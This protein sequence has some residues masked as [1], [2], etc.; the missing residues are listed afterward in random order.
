[1]DKP[2]QKSLGSTFLNAI[3]P[4]ET[5]LAEDF[6]EWLQLGLKTKKI[7]FNTYESDIHV[8]E[9]GLFLEIPDI[10]K[11][12]CAQSTK[13]PRWDQVFAQLK[14]IGLISKDETRKELS[15][16][17][18]ANDDTHKQLA[19]ILQSDLY[20][21]KSQLNQV[22]QA[23]QTTKPNKKSWMPFIK[24][25]VRS[26]VKILKPYFLFLLFANFLG[27]PIEFNFMS[28]FS[29]KS[30]LEKKLIR[31]KKIRRR[32][33]RL[34]R[35][36]KEIDE[37]LRLQKEDILNKLRILRHNMGKTGFH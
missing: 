31:L 17:T 14:K 11:K 26:G 2:P 12:F 34:K 32:R 16:Y 1:L 19:P 3:E 10:L 20:N 15:V 24:P 18:Y 25:K 5:A 29:K 30:K 7:P 9:N 33:R 13:N 36:K 22:N 37:S 6:L 8:I 28:I 27:L 4:A 23:S 21:K 35:L